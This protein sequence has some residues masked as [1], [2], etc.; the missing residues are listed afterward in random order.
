MS[1]VTGPLHTGL[2]HGGGDGLEFVRP[3]DTCHEVDEGGSEVGLVVAKLGRF[4]VPGEDVVV[5]VPALTNGADG[6][7]QVLRGSNRL[8]VRSVSPLVGGTVHQPGH[9]QGEHV[10]EHGGHEPGV[11][12]GLAPE[13]HGDHGRHDETAEGHK[14]QVILLLEGQDGVALQVGHVDTLALGDDVG[15][16]AAQ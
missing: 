11:K 4:V 16:L 12:E 9:V 15:V 10:A 2:H 7:T 13:V 1:A 5:V 14:D 3:A 6:N 8:I